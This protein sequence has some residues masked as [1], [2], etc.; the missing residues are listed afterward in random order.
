MASI[1]EAFG[2]ST[3]FTITLNTLASSATAARESTVVD[4]TSDLYLD[5]LV[6]VQVNVAT[7]TI[8]NDKCVY[9]YAYSSVDGTNYVDNVTGSDA[10]ITLND[11]TNLRLIGVISVPTQS[12]TYKGPAMSV[13]AAFGGVLPPK[14][15]IVVRNYSG[16]ALGSSSSASWRGVYATSA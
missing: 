13:A 10:A 9:V 5:A 14:W 1:K 15:G 6:Y 3:S 7:G 16:I 8:A 2:P 11:P 4:N 12:T